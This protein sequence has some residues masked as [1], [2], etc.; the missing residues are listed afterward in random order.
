MKKSGTFLAVIG[1]LIGIGIILSVY[2]NFLMFED[3]NKGNGD[4]FP[5][6]DLTI[7]VELDHTKTQTGIFAVQIIDFEGETVTASILDPFNSEV[8]TNSINEELYEG[9]FD[10]TTSGT[11]KLFIENKGEQVKIFGVIG[12]EPEAW[13]KS[14]DLISFIILAIGLIGMVGIAAYMIIIR[15]KDVS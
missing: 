15:K 3:L 1:G 14:L 2:G 12:P 7:E 4:V 13:K 5:G 11:Y 9:F 8:E 10:V 6:Q